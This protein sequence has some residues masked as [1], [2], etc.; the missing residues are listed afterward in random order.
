MNLK[1]KL[2]LLL[3]ASSLSSLILLIGI[4]AVI[5]LIFNQGYTHHNLSEL[6]N[7]LSR[8]MEQIGPDDEQI[9][10]QL[11]AFRNEHPHIDLTWLS[12]NGELRYATDGRTSD[13]NMNELMNRFLNMPS[14]LWEN[15]A[16]ITLI[17]DWQWEGL[18]QFLVM[19]LPSEVMQSSQIF[20]YIQ[21]S[22]QFIQLLLP[23]ALFML[24]PYVFAL[25]FFLKLNRRLQLLNQ[26]MIT[27]DA[28]GAHEVD[29]NASKDEIGQLTRSFND[30]SARIRSNIIRIRELEAKRKLL[31]A[32]ISND[33]RTPLTMIIGYAESLD[34][35]IVKSPE[36][37][38]KYM[39]YLLRRATYMDVL[40]QKLLEIAQLDTYKDRVQLVHQDLGETIRLIAAD[41]IPVV[42]SM[43]IDMDF[44]I[45]EQPLYVSF[46]Q[47]LIERA[48]R[49]LI[50]NAIQHGGEGKYLGIFLKKT[51]N[52]VHIT[53][54]DRGPGIELA[55][56]RFIFE[57][58]YRGPEGRGGEGLGLGLSIVQ[59]VANAHKGYVR[60]ESRPNEKTKFTLIL[61]YSAKH[62]TQASQ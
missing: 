58:F 3:L 6:G 2:W 23:V 62:E 41:Y 53:I 20:I 12:E 39:T 44:H 21:N 8:M 32:D 36:E 55:K 60:M 4:A 30:M 13:Y 15:E 37:K 46:D 40:L 43:S 54:A 24:T 56:Q 51:K 17:F 35:Q 7:Q 57:R 52:Q 48:L 9:Q 14:N 16:E 1:S 47:P 11:A 28:S 19:S 49:N 31:I 10:Q 59:E 29:E 50:E 42:E 5:G 22:A 34:K 18:Q 26:A 25:F 38:K 27:F 45:P 33:L 61:P